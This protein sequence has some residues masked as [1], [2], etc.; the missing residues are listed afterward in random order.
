MAKLARNPPSTFA[1]LLE[2]AQKIFRVRTSLNP[3]S[4]R[5]K[6]AQTIKRGPNLATITRMLGFL[7]VNR[8]CE[9]CGEKS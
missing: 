3:A 6:L 5:K 8:H 9:R 7:G 2:M 4:M 1:K